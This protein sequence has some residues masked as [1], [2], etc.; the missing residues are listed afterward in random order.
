M[1][2]HKPIYRSKRKTIKR[3]CFHRF[4]NPRHNKYVYFWSS[5]TYLH[6]NFLCFPLPI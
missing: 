4:T 1:T 2:K 6:I 3:A 5:A